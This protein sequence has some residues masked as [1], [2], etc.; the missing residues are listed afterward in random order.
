MNQK[1]VMSILNMWEHMKSSIEMNRQDNGRLILLMENQWFVF[2][3]YSK[4]ILRNPGD[5]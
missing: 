5:S 1:G 3:E 4:H 2:I